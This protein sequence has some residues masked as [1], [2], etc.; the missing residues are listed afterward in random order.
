KSIMDYL[1]RWMGLKFLD[2]APPAPKG[3]VDVHGDRG[4]AKEELETAGQIPLITSSAANAIDA[5][6]CH[7][8]GSIMVPNGSCYKCVNCGE[9]SGCS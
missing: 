1:F 7:N 2:H 3:V 5:P 8:C 6:A 4:E 9:T